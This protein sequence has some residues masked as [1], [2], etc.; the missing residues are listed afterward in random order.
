MTTINIAAVQ[1]NLKI[2]YADGMEY[3]GYD[4]RPFLGMVPKVTKFEGKNFTFAVQNANNQG[5]SADFVK[6][7]INSGANVY[8]DFVLN[9]RRNYGR[10]AI[11]GEVLAASTGKGAFVEEITATINGTVDTFSDDVAC[12]LFRS[13]S[14]SRGVIAAFPTPNTLQLTNATDAACFDVNMRLEAS[15][16]DG[17][18]VVLGGAATIT[19][20]DRELGILTTGGAGW[21]AQIP[22]LVPGNFLFTDGD[23]DLKIQGLKDWIPASTAGLATPFNGVIR[24]VDPVRL[25]GQRFNGGGAPI[26]ESINNGVGQAMQQGGS[27]FD[28]LLMSPVDMQSLVNALTNRIREPRVATGRAMGSKGPIAEIGYEG[29]MI[30]TPMGK[31]IKVFADPWCPVGTGYLLTMDSWVLRSTAKV[32]DFLDFDGVGKILRLNDQDAYEGRIGC[33][34]NLMCSRPKDNMVF[35]W[36]LLRPV[37]SSPTSLTA[38]LRVARYRHS[39][40][41]SLAEIYRSSQ[42]APIFCRSSTIQSSGATALRPLLS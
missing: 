21:V 42:T 32:P 20:I 37:V 36:L 3:L 14:G 18:T 4:S 7:G 13:G 5:R 19:A 26:E 17:G 31:T 1:N 22:G 6:A 40:S 12:N 35:T 8:N 33:Y 30:T 15:V 11:E 38:P 16:T 2:V 25:A 24:S 10:F 41:C 23:Y 9:R 27:K 28:T 39:S 29:I 34:A